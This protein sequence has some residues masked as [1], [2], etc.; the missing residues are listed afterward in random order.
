MKGLPGQPAGVHQGPQTGHSRPCCLTDIVGTSVECSSECPPR[1]P[2]DPAVHPR[3]LAALC[4]KRRRVPALTQWTEPERPQASEAR[5][6]VLVFVT[7]TYGSHTAIGSRM[8]SVQRIRMRAREKTAGSVDGE[9]VKRKR[10]Q[11]LVG[12]I[13]S[14]FG[15]L[16]ISLPFTFQ[17]SFF[18][19]MFLP[20]SQ[21]FS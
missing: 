6:H 15:T 20:F 7:P 9:E 3:P 16:K 5:S 8:N 10:V 17:L 13:A 19:R 11:V 18:C 21:W 14:L 12:K 4:S 2:P 1:P